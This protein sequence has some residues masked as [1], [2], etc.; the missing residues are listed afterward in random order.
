MKSIKL[1][2][3]ILIIFFKTGNVLSESDIFNVSNIEV[4]KK[5]EIT[6]SQMSRQAIKKGFQELINKILLD[7]DKEKL[8]KLSFS[9]IQELVSYYQV[10]NKNSNDTEESIENYNILFDKDKIHDLFFVKEISYSEIIDKELYLLP[11]LNK[12]NQIFIFNQNFFYQ[13]WNNENSINLIE[14][15][16]PIENIE[17]IQN[18]NTYKD[19][20]LDLNLDDLFKEYQKKNLAMIYIDDYSS[21]KLK[22]FL[23]IK[24]S[25][26]EISKNLNLNKNIKKENDL[27]KELIIQLKNELINTI[28]SENLID[29]RRPSFLNVKLKL[30]K[31]NSLIELN[32]RLKNID[33]IENIYVQELNSNYVFL[34]IKYL[35]RLAKI[36]NQLENQKILLRE[37]GNQWSFKLI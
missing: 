19:N 24:I 28:K 9:Q 16:L 1:Y 21:T 23:K 20:L 18:I 15:I 3:V 8:S 17:I 22:I 32:K 12:N 35:G 5:A 26:K 25:G 4:L 27:Y 33:S 6:N 10:T 34:K 14:F 7:Q 37:T 29:V 36:I 30:S 13:N 11:I 2:F 31:K